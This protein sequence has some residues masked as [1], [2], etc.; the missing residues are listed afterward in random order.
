M[1]SMAWL[2]FVLVDRYFACQILQFT[3]SSSPGPQKSA[4][5][6]SLWIDLYKSVTNQLNTYPNSIDL[7]DMD[8]SGENKLVVGEFSG[9]VSVYKGTN[10]VWQ[11]QLSEEINALGQ[12]N[13]PATAKSSKRD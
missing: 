6:Q 11:V 7:I 2:P 4:Q 12:F 9:L 1:P 10:I 8:D 3:M 5:Q 13:L